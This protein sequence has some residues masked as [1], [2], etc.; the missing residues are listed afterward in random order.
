MNSKIVLQFISAA[1]VTAAILAA[2]VASAAA[3]VITLP[4]TAGFIEENWSGQPVAS[5]TFESHGTALLILQPLT[6]QID[7]N[8][9]NGPV[10]MAAFS[11][12]DLA[13]S[14]IQ[15]HGNISGAG[16]LLQPGI[17]STDTV[18]I[19]LWDNLPNA[20]GV[21]LTEATAIGVAGT[22]VD[23]FWTA[24]TIT[25]GTT[26]YL[27]F[28]GNTTLGIAGD[29]SNPYP[30]GMVYANPGFSSFPSF[31][32]AFRTYYDDNV[33]IERHTWANVKSLFD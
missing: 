30:F 22:W 24:F 32:Y 11:Q 14:F 33:V 9:P 15:T 31:D 1:I 21:M 12:T 18:T 2:P 7:Q 27:V 16:I 6:N 25:P 28:T 20:G 13:Q 23:V 29:T 8:Q 4:V 3:D 10:Y 17:G 5:S 26:Y 19:Q